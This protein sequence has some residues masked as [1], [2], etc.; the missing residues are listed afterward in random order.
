MKAYKLFRLRKDNTLGPL[1]IDAKL[2]IPTDTWMKSKLGKP[3]KSSWKVRQGWHCCYQP[4][5][6][7]LNSTITSRVWCEVEVRHTTELP[8]PDRLGGNWILAD[9]LKVVR[10]LTAQEVKSLTPKKYA[11]H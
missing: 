6:P 11:N 8:R 4:V 1:F 7:H 5:A 10:R 2:R 3:P 9:E